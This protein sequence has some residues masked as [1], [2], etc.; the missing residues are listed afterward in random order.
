MEE[1]WIVFFFELDLY[2]SLVWEVD[3]FDFDILV[4]KCFFVGELRVDVLL[5]I[6]V[7]FFIDL[8]VLEFVVDVVLFFFFCVFIIG[9]F[10]EWMVEVG[11]FD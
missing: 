9:F 2:N 8:L 10:I 7:K 4:N 6:E 5:I 1:F 3:L 11:K